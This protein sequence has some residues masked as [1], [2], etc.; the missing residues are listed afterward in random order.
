MADISKNASMEQ[1]RTSQ[2]GLGIGKLIEGEAARDAIHVAIAPAVAATQLWPGQDVG[3][4]PDGKVGPNAKHIGIVDPFL[5][6]DDRR[7]LAGSKFWLFLYPGSITSLRHEWT[8]DYFPSAAVRVPETPPT[9]PIEISRAWIND[10]AAKL[11]QTP[12]RL[13]SAAAEWLEYE[14]YTRDDSES[15]KGHWDEFPEFWEHYAVVT[16][17]DIPKDKRRSFFT[18]SC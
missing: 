8:H 1:H 6:G 14:E 16:G 9:D 10:F 12:N 5:Q 4:Q 3:I 17:K 18:C 15:Y 2:E 13:M 7:V 11:D